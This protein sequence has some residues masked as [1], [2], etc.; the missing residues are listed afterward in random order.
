M[1]RTIAIM[2]FPLASA[3]HADPLACLIEPDKVAEIGV[4]GIGIINKIV[5]ERGDV[6]KENQILAYLRSDIERASV[7]VA[8][9]RAQ[10]EADL[11]AALAAQEL[12]RSKVTRARSLVEVGFI[13]AEAL[14]QA[15]AEARI[16]HNRV[17]QAQEGKRIAQQELALSN[18][19][20][21][22]RTIRSPFAGIV[23]DRYRTE[24]ERI[25]REPVLRLAKVDPLRVE[26]VLPLS[27]FGKIDVG[28]QATITTDVATAK[29][30]VATVVLIDRMVDAASNTFRVRLSLPN[31]DY[32]IPAGLRCVAAFGATPALSKQGDVP[33]NGASGASGLIEAAQFSGKPLISGRGRL[34]YELMNVP[35]SQ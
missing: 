4:P 8:T 34:S 26:V 9:V 7:N 6:V 18:S 16:A 19:Q 28:A 12:A 21:A 11:K 5:V 20:L 32:R 25:E 14:D 23:V 2:L 33:D 35:K 29:N 30:L 15:E 27:Q 17:I 10:A 24:G 22:Q 13:S 1:R 3:A 31:P